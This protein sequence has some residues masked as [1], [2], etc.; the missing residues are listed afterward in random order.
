MKPADVKA[1]AVE[2]E[3]PRANGAIGASDGDLRGELLKAA[4]FD[5]L[6]EAPAGKKGARGYAGR[7]E[8]MNDVKSDQILEGVIRWI[9]DRF[10]EEDLDIRPETRLLETSLLNSMDLLEMVTHIEEQY[11]IEV[12]PDDLIPENFES[13]VKIVQLVAKSHP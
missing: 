11:G 13:P 5:T 12:D 8:S 9:Q 2:L 4:I 7:D 10:P 1:F 3:G 6:G